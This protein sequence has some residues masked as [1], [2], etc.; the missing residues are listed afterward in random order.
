MKA[1]IVLRVRMLNAKIHSFFCVRKYKWSMMREFLAF[2]VVFS[3]Q[4]LYFSSNDLWARNLCRDIWN[5]NHWHV[6]DTC[7]HAPGLG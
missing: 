3:R 1:V 2:G 4:S 7:G 6:Q 5:F